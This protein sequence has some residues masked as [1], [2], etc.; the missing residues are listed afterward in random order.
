M[1]PAVASVGLGRVRVRP[2]VVW[3]RSKVVAT[4][5]VAAAVPMVV[6]LVMLAMVSPV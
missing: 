2:E 5:T 1:R 4:L 6:L 3:L